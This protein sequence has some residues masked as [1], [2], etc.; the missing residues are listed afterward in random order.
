MGLKPELV[1]PVGK[2]SDYLLNVAHPSGGPKALFFIKNGFDPADPEQLIRA[3]MAHFKD[4][5]EILEFE[6]AF[7]R[8]LVASGDMLFPNGKLFSVWSVWMN[9]TGTDVIKLVTAFRI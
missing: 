7:G 5:L 6:G 4:S 2:V 1:I 3:L 9:E 8:R